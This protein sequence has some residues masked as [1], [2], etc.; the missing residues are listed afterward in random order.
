MT[1]DLH[2]MRPE[3][4]LDLLPREFDRFRER[5]ASAER[6]PRRTVRRDRRESRA[7]ADRI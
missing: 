3:Q 4:I 5:E 1:C 7:E 2:A 6:R